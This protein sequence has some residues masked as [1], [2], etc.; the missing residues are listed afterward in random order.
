VAFLAAAI[1]WVFRKDIELAGFTILGWSR[2]VPWD[3]KE[4]IEA[5]GW[6]APVQKIFSDPGDA[7][8]SMMIAGLLLFIP[9]RRKTAEEPRF[10][11]TVQRARGVAW[12]MLVLLGG[13][14]A[15]AYGIQA[16]G[17]SEAIAGNLSHIGKMNLFVAMLTVSFISVALTEVASNTA[18]ASILL[19]ILAASAGGVGLDPLPL[20]LAVTMSASFGFML[21]AGTPPNAIVYSSGYI[22]V[23]QMA[24]SGLVVDLF[25]AALVATICYF[26]VPWVLGG[27]AK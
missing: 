27:V 2:L 1:L 13:G 10:A 20:M 21:P 5:T 3:W 12:G 24:R 17:L 15:M 11:L 25:G 7:V 18:T 6:S 4:I 8:V 19:P 23:P 14:F 16:S 26:L 9:V 22:T